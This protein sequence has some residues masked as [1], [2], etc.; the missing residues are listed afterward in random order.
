M[1]LTGYWIAG[2]CQ[3]TQAEALAAVSAQYPQ[4]HNGLMLS[5]TMPQF[6][7]ANNIGLWVQN[8][9]LQTGIVGGQWVDFPVASCDPVIS[10]A[11]NVQMFNDGMQMGWGIIAAMAGALAVIFLKKSFFR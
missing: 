1:A 6:T 9:N 7:A 11:V 2:V 4:V 5:A 3:S 8:Q 10:Q